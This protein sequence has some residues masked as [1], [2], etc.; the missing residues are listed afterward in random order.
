MATLTLTIGSAFL[1][2]DFAAVVRAP[3]TEASSPEV[4]QTIALRA[5]RTEFQSKLDK[6][7]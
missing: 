4:K 5:V 1:A 3:L 7:E 2:M 6:L